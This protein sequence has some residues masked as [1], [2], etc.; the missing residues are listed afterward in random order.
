MN[1][2]KL[3]DYFSIY[4]ARYNLRYNNEMDIHLASEKAIELFI[5]DTYLSYIPKLALNN[6][7][8][9]NIYFIFYYVKIVSK[10]AT[11]ILLITHI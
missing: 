6:S 10:L 11:Y 5:P 9:V 8:E 7:G 1:I 4:E 3:I 2:I